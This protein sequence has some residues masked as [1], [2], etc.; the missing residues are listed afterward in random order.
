MNGIGKSVFQILVKGDANTFIFKCEDP[1]DKENIG[2][3]A[4]AV[5]ISGEVTS[6]KSS[7]NHIN[8]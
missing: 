7:C 6:H 5:F 8:M 2:N 3:K 4:V 1:T